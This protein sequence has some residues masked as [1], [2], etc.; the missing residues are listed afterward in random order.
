MT[1]SP[2]LHIPNPRLSSN[3]LSL[4]PTTI[5]FSQL[6][7]LHFTPMGLSY[8][9]L[10]LTQKK[11][12]ALLLTRRATR[13]VSRGLFLSFSVLSSSHTKTSQRGVRACRE[14]KVS[15]F[16][17]PTRK[18]K[19]K[20]PARQKYVNNLSPARRERFWS[21]ERFLCRLGWDKRLCFFVLSFQ[22]VP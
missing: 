21:L 16:E 12:L 14:K 10:Y 4:P 6:F 17:T 13:T 3:P 9:I 15:S 22:P 5:F 7:S 1:P 18:K 8:L 19:K 20:L 2:H 11:S